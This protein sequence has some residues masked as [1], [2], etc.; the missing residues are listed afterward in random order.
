MFAQRGHRNQIFKLATKEKGADPELKSADLRC[1]LGAAAKQTEALIGL[2]YQ[3]RILLAS[4]LQPTAVFHHR[5]SSVETRGLGRFIFSE[6]EELMDFQV[7]LFSWPDRGN[8]LI[9]IARGVMEIRGF[10]QIFREVLTATQALRDCK[11]VIDLQDTACNL[12]SADI[13]A[14]V[15]GGELDLWPSNNKMA[16]V[17]PHELEQHDQ[18]ATL[19]SGLAKRGLKIAVFHDSKRAITWLAD[20]Q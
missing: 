6:V 5:S 20:M 16:I 13:R 10:E 1:S 3:H 8:H 14:F 7:K 19:A 15:E 12:E 9:M 18:L 11:V 17:S 4:R 2:I